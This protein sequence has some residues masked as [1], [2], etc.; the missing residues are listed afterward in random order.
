MAEYLVFTLSANMSAMGGPAGHERR[1]TMTTPGKSAVIGLLG[2]A[3][4]LE[5]MD[6]EGFASLDTLNLAV[7][8]ILDGNHLRDFHTVQTVP[9][10]KAKRPDSRPTALHQAGLGV[11][12]AITLRDYRCGAVFGVALWGRADLIRLAEALRTPVFHLYF[13]RKS[14]PLSSPLAAKVIEADDPE[15]ALQQVTLPFW[16]GMYAGQS[17]HVERDATIDDSGKIELRHDRALDRSAWHF[18][19][20]H[21]VVSGGTE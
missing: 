8:R 11:N 2:A 3:L 17:R 10:A 1:G 13:G 20:R 7:S 5:R 21:V 4:G 19:S 12:T 16:I 9:T 6:A 15:M 14:C 18:G